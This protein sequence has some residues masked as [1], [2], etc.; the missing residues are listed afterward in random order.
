MSGDKDS[1]FSLKV[2]INKQKNKVLFAEIENDFANVLLG[3]MTLPLGRIVQVLKNHYGEN[4]PLVGSLNSLYNGVANL[5]CSH[6]KSFD[7]KQMLLDPPSAYSSPFRNMNLSFFVSD[8]V[9]TDF[10]LGKAFTGNFLEYSSS[11][12]VSDDLWMVP[13]VNRSFVES[14]DYVGV[15]LSEMDGAHTITVTFGLSEV[16]DLLKG[17][18]ISRH[19]LTD[20]ILGTKWMNSTPEKSESKISLHDLI[21][22]EASLDSKGTIYL[23]I[24]F[25]KSTKKFLFAQADQDFVDLLFS[26]LV[27]PL[28]AAERPFEFGTGLTNIDNLY[29]SITYMKRELFNG[30]DTQNW[31]L[32]YL[33]FH[34]TDRQTFLTSPEVEK[35]N[36][37]DSRSRMY[38]VPDD[39]TVTPFSVCSTLSLLKRMKISASDVEELDLHAGVYK[40]GLCILKASLTSTRAMT[41]GLINYLQLKRHTTAVTSDI[42]RVE[43]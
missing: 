9:P 28:G 5:D 18:F 37:V 22:N 36:F 7:V 25:E 26:L 39:L 19:P 1:T 43:K 35:P 41:D 32:G 3:F 42:S 23:K 31:L 6:F 21:V 17:S 13:N 29:N 2:V 30:S 12:I 33:I 20:I 14:L 40:L 27:I 8:Y 10:H 4:T 11:F 16:M 38:I 24:T 15:A 34:E